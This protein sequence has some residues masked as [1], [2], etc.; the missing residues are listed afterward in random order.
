MSILV[1]L[2]GAMFGGTIGT[3]FLCFFIAG[4]DEK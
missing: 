4:R 1:Y 2:G 3:L